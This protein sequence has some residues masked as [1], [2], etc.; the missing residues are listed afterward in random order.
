MDHYYKDEDYDDDVNYHDYYHDDDDDDDQHH[1]H[2]YDYDDYDTAAATTTT[3]TTTA[4][5]APA[6]A[7]AAAATANG[8]SNSNIKTTTTMMVGG[9]D[10]LPALSSHS[11]QNCYHNFSLSRSGNIAV[12]MRIIAAIGTAKLNETSTLAQQACN[13]MN[14]KP[15]L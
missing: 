12:A 14:P 8:A 7:A 2:D 5:A 11:T 6:A 9:T 4:A 1:D 3:A 10:V 15:K 13:Q